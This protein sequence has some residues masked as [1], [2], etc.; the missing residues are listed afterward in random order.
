MRCAHLLAVAHGG[1]GLVCLKEVP[2]HLLDLPGIVN[3]QVGER[4][5]CEVS[6]MA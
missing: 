2:H 3:S 6:T 1:D 4:T 5:A